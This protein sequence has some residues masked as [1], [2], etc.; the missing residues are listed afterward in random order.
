MPMI[1]AQK[2]KATAC[3]GKQPSLSRNYRNVLVVRARLAG[4]PAEAHY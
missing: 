4:R 2:F 3:T 1:S